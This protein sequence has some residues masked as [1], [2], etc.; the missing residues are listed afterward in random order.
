MVCDLRRTAHTLSQIFGLRQVVAPPVLRDAL[1]VEFEP[2]PE[3]EPEPEFFS[4]SRRSGFLGGRAQV[5]WSSPTSPTPPIG[6]SADVG[7]NIVG[8]CELYNGLYKA[9]PALKVELLAAL[10]FTLKSPSLVVELWRQIDSEG[11]AHKHRLLCNA[12][13]LSGEPF[14]CDMRFV[15]AREPVSLETL[16]NNVAVNVL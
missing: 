4:P 5:G 7:A 14:R 15:S 6:Q 13:D 1:D 3:P 10:C 11:G 2:E 9:L 16:H 12:A 8:A